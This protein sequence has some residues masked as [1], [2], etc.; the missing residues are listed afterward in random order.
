MI[1]VI[2]H[3]MEEHSVDF[4]SVICLFVCNTIDMI[5][6]S[7]EVRVVPFSNYKDIWIFL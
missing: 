2:S 1:A 7:T 6:S 4:Y 3:N 5:H